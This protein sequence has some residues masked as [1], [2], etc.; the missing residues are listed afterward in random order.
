M[1]SESNQVGLFP[2]RGSVVPCC[3]LSLVSVTCDGAVKPW[4]VTPAAPGRPEHQ[5]AA[6][7]GGPNPWLL[8]GPR[9]PGRP[10]RTKVIDLTFHPASGNRVRIGGYVLARHFREIRD[11]SFDLRPNFLLGRSMTFEQ[12]IAYALASPESLGESCI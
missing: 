6:K 5:K 1:L 11:T 10:R 12:A 8:A 4:F 7:G 2:C 3:T 9:G